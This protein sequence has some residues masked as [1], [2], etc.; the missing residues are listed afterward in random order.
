MDGAAPKEIAISK[1]IKAV[2]TTGGT[3]VEGTIGLAAGIA[4][5]KVYRRMGQN[6]GYQRLFQLAEKLKAGIET[7]FK[8]R[9]V[10]LHINILGPYLKLFF[11]DLAPSYEAYD[12]LDTRAVALFYTSLITEGVFLGNPNLRATFLSFVHTAEDVQEIID[13]VNNSLAKYEFGDVV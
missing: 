13:A 5:M 10:P 3:Y 1:G 9:G 6:G 8:E 7:V 4:A 12:V 2:T 11:T